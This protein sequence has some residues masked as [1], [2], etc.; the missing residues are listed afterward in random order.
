VRVASRQVLAPA[1]FLR[2]LTLSL[3]LSLFALTSWSDEGYISDNNGCKIAN[4]NPKPDERVTWSGNCKDGFADGEGI[5]QWSESNQP[6]GRY[7]GTLVRGALSGQGKLTL[8]DGTSYDGGWLDGKQHGTG[9]L[10][11]ADGGSYRGG[12]KSG[13]PDGR[14][15]MRR[16]SG[17]AVRGVWKDGV[18]IGP[19]ND[20]SEPA[21]DR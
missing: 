4:P 12:W 19:A 5:L 20:P 14:G 9:T 3:G 6:G 7:E 10:K 21:K 13:Q 2:Q 11:D 8:P 18:Y 15:V 16:A 17:D 1:N